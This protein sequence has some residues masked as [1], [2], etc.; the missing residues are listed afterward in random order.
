[1]THC[2]HSPSYPLPKEASY[3]EL[4]GAEKNTAL[5][6]CENGLDETRGTVLLLEGGEWRSGCSEVGGK[7]NMQIIVHAQEWMALHRRQQA[8]SLGQ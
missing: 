7:I 1:M 2:L 5:L 4:P 6:Q 3:L 8:G